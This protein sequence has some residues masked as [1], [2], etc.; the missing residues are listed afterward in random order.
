LDLK[1]M[2][3]LLNE[4]Q[5]RLN[6]KLSI[7][8]WFKYKSRLIIYFAQKGN[9]ADAASELLQLREALRVQGSAH[10]AVYVNLAEATVCFHAGSTA[11]AIEKSRRA[12][13]LSNAMCDRA[14]I[15]Q[16]SAWLSHFY[17]NTGRYMDA[18]AAASESLGEIGVC[19]KCSVVRASLVVADLYHFFE[20][21]ISAKKWYDAARSGALDEGDEV[22][23]GIILYNIA[24]HRLNG[25]RLSD[26]AGAYRTGDNFRL[27]LE[28]A[29][30]SNYDFGVQSSAFPVFLPLLN[31]QIFTLD[32]KFSE[33]AEIF[34]DCLSRGNSGDMRRLYPAIRADY[35]WC[36]AN[37]GRRIEALREIMQVV[38]ELSLADA[39]DDRAF[40]LNRA[41]LTYGLLGD[42]E[43][44]LAYKAEMHSALEEHRKIQAIV[45]ATLNSQSWA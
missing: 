24:T 4:I 30:S 16:S 10:G 37:L 14:L 29:S 42:V 2:S 28:A 40:A 26:L 41:S 12:H 6:E 7:R 31:A 32:R 1:I 23:T 25:A 33:A 11:D 44:A 13:A 22:M 18:I 3:R 34:E 20:D 19:E 9:R 5:Q 17:F 27:S 45:L 38:A 36:L 21:A 15:S 43:L 39:P 8:D 35:A